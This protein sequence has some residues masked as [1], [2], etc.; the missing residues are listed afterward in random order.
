[1]FCLANFLYKEGCTLTASV[2]HGV[3]FAPLTMVIE[4]LVERNAGGLRGITEAAARTKL[5]RIL[6][7]EE[8]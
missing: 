6:R 2:E 7:E 3:K 1:M 5:E 4:D 8:E